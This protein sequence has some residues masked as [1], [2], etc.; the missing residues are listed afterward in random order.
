MT[1]GGG[2]GGISNL[3]TKGMW[4]DAVQLGPG[5]VCE[6]TRDPRV[7]LNLMPGAAPG[8][9]LATRCRSWPPRP[10]FDRPQ[11]HVTRGQGRRAP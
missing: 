11:F 10:Q 8:P 3:P 6:G 1:V 4:G 5:W 9:A 2:G 7:D